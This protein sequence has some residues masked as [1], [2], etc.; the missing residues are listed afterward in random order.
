MLGSL[1]GGRID[2]LSTTTT[3]RKKKEEEE[4]GNGEELSEE[5]QELRGYDRKVYRACKDMAAATAKELRK[6]EVPFFCVMDGL[7][8]EK[9]DGKAQGKRKGTIS[10]QELVEL[11]GRMMGLLED[12]CGED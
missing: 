5:E 9:G 6:L 3:K 11:R 7:V 4:E 12:L 2:L 8:S 10:E 1:G